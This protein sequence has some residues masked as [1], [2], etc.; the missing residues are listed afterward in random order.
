MGR[1]SVG[2]WAV[3]AY[4]VSAR[5]VVV[6]LKTFGSLE[7]AEC[8][9]DLIVGRVP[10]GHLIGTLAPIPPSA[11]RWRKYGFNQAE[12][13]AKAVAVKTELPFARLLSRTNSRSQVGLHRSGRITNRRNGFEPVS[14]GK[15]PNRVTLVDDVVTTG[16]TVAAASR[17]LYSAGVSQVNF[18][19][20]ARTL[21]S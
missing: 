8:I 20:F 6:A 18:V 2:G 7:L 10:S 21:R 14:R 1:I 9:G 13:I 12:L 16:S 17:A 15:I 3:T 19:A 4:A 11:K 5:P